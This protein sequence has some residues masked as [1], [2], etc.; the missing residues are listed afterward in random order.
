MSTLKVSTQLALLVGVLSALLV[1][2]AGLGW[3]GS[4]QM[5]QA[6]TT[7]LE[8]RAPA[9]VPSPGARVDALGTADAEALARLATVRTLSIATLALGLLFAGVAGLRLH[10]SLARRIGAEPEAAVALAQA[11]AGGDLRAAVV[12]RDGDDTSLMAR[13]VQVQERLATVVAQVREDASS[14]AATS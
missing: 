13:L 11:V 1:A 8:A 9:S 3:Y 14:L 2:M 5:R 12:L 6:L 4:D 7:P 10:R